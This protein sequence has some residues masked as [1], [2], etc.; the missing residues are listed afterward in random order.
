MSDL[1]NSPGI[2]KYTCTCT[3][4][5]FDRKKIVVTLK[6]CSFF[7]VE[8]FMMGGDGTGFYL[9]MNQVRTTRS[10]GKAL[11]RVDYVQYIIKVGLLVIWVALLY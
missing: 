3:I 11:Y 1:K 7:Y 10:L 4:L 8:N 5:P 2:L 9:L 6:V